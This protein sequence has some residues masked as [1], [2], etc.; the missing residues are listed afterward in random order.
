MNI[1][2]FPR[3]SF[4]TYSGV[5]LVLGFSVSFILMVF[6]PFGTAEFKHDYKLFI[7][8][9]YGVVVASA[10]LLYYSLSY[11]II[12]R[13]RESSWNVI[14]ESIDLFLVQIFSMC[15]CYFYFRWVFDYSFNFSG[16]L[17]FLKIAA[18]V[19]ILPSLAVSY[20]LFI[21]YKGVIRSKIEEGEKSA[22][23]KKIMIKGLTRSDAVEVLSE[24]VLHVKAEDNYVILHILK[25]GVEE[26]HMIRSTLKNIKEQ[27]NNPSF[28]QC[29]RSHLINIDRAM[30]I[31]GNKNKSRLE[32]KGSSKKIPI[33]R[34]YYD[35]IKEHLNTQKSSVSN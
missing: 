8:L 29:H 18:S 21:R 32:I 3:P 15:A 31:E 1:A 4:S 16:M 25:N 27:L 17:S 34:A 26:R 22:I 30:E 10:I 28:F 19:S 7:L 2:P 12:N 35:E 24:D 23:S 6:Q 9:G 11:F 5:A 13:K 20:Y 14:H 33:A